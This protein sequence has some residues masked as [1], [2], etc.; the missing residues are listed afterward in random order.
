[1]RYGKRLTNYNNYGSLIELNNTRGS[2]NM[3]TDFY[4]NEV[5]STPASDNRAQAKGEEYKSYGAVWAHFS[6]QV[7]NG[8]VPFYSGNIEVKE[9]PQ[10]DKDGKIAFMMFPNNKR[11]QG[12]ND[13]HY[14][15]VPARDNK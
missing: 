6:K 10:P 4:D 3:A 15:L 5:P 8:E 12:T 9:L 11:R 13:P 7:M 14:Y 1:M 2:Y